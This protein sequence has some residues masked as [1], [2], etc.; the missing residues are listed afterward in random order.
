M[1]T[2]EADHNLA[3]SLGRKAECSRSTASHLRTTIGLLQ[4]SNRC[5][6]FSVPLPVHHDW[7]QLLLLDVP[8]PCRV[9]QR[10][11]KAR[12]VRPA[13]PIWSS[14]DAA[15]LHHQCVSN[16]TR[17]EQRLTEW[18]HSLPQRNHLCKAKAPKEPSQQDVG[19]DSRDAS[20]GEER[21]EARQGRQVALAGAECK[22]AWT[23]VDGGARESLPRRVLLD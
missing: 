8:G 14:R 13:H 2:A 19:R 18:P 20:H 4:R 17:N 9:I 5:V 1:A 15:G 22:T 23:E 10:V 11:S 7:I 21:D 12:V 3:S 6:G 16:R